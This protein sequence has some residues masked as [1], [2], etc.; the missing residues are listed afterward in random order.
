MTRATLVVVAL[1]LLTVGWTGPFAAF[2]ADSFAGHMARHML[3][4]TLVPVVF[5]LGIA[6]TRIDPTTR[7]PWLFSPLIASLVD[8]VIVWVWHMPAL[9]HAARLRW[10]AA[11]A[12][13]GAFLCAG[14][15]LWVAILGGGP[16]RR[17][18][19]AGQS[20]VALVL[21]FAH[22]TMLGALLALA[23]RAL[24]MHP[25]FALQPMALADQQMGGALMLAVSAVAYVGAGVWLGRYLLRAGPGREV[26]L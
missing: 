10:D 23:P 14:L 4:V 22:M 15:W 7:V 13:Q 6:G 12:E 16:E 21:T 19:V 20:V 24:F 8:L 11:V 9:H 26:S 2:A 5:V 25:R 3:L 17:A 18:A 1:V